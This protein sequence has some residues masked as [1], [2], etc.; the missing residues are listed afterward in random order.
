MFDS[1]Y[2]RRTFMK[3]A[4]GAAGSLAVA[5]ASGLI[6][7]TAFGAQTY[8]GVTYYT[9]SYRGII[10]VKREAIER[11]KQN[12][13]DRFKVDFYDSGTLM[14]AD[15]QTS[16]LRSGTIQFMFHTTSYITRSFKILGIT[17]LPSLVQ[18]LYQN[19]DRIKM[20]SPLW[21]LINDELAKDN[22]FMLTA[23]GGV[24]E[25]EYVWSG[26]KQISSLGDL[27]GKRL[28]IVSY[29]A[30]ESLK[31]F[32]V[33]GVRIPSS[34]TYLAL[35]RGTVDG[36]VLNI[37]TTMGRRLYEQ[38]KHCYELPVTAYTVGLFM[39][40]KQWDKLDDATRAAFWDAAQFYDN[41]FCS[42]I[43]TKWAKDVYWP[44]IEQAGVTMNQPTPAE[45]GTFR[46][47]AQPVWDW[48]CNE[49]GED[50]GRKAIKLALGEG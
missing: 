40:K 41:T 35:Q 4:G 26:D 11:L 19:G 20:E 44:E 13:G 37:T 31:Q 48:W 18:E 42:R 47:K 9:P 46:E 38:L 2:S 29:E 15:E 34:E 30:T 7:S 17:G 49:V 43:N 39:L 16:A 10:E 6:P 5:G 22:I 8:R 36:A 1:R 33:A 28:R 21:K 23:G 32:G 12:A 27:Q 50:V 45:A 24:L 25:P 3:I 14:K